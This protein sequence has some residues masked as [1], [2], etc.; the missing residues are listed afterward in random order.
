MLLPAIASRKLCPRD[1]KMNVFHCVD[2]KQIAMF[3][4]SEAYQLARNLQVLHMAEAF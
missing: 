3:S 1:G 4:S 2:D